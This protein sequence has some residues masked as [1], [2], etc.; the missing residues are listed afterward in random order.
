MHKT[1]G[2]EKLL[3]DRV[4]T[5]TSSEKV[6]ATWRNGSASLVMI[7]GHKEWDK[8]ETVPVSRKP[9]TLSVYTLK[10]ERSQ[11]SPCWEIYLQKWSYLD[12]RWIHFYDSF[13]IYNAKHVH[14]LHRDPEIKTCMY[15]GYK[16]M[17]VYIAGCSHGF[18]FVENFLGKQKTIQEK[19]KE[20]T[21]RQNSKWFHFAGI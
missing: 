7:L 15:G 13:N 12:I 8:G 14:T 16:H 18:Y 4:Q 1:W 20:A 10:G 5:R 17:C 19:W 3:E 11:A 6:A 9:V 2:V 21:R